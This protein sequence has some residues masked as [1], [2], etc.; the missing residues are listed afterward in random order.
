VILQRPIDRSQIDFAVE[1]HDPVA[2]PRHGSQVLCECAIDDAGALDQ[3]K[4]FGVRR[5]NAQVV[6]RTDVGGDVDRRLDGEFQRVEHGVLALP[7]FQKRRFANAGEVA[8]I[9]DVFANAALAIADDFD[10]GDHHRFSRIAS[11]TVWNA[12]SRSGLKSK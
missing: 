12:R 9:A 4:G 7:V 11:R 6:G 2:E 1:L 3:I 10:V 5:G 8:Q